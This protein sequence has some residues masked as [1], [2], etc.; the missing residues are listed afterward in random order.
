[1]VSFTS[2]PPDLIL[3][4]A[5]F[6]D[7]TS[8]QQLRLLNHDLNAIVSPL[9]LRNICFALAD[10]EEKIQKLLECCSQPLPALWEY[11]RHLTIRTMGRY[12]AAQY[13]DKERISGLYNTIEQFKH[14][15]SFEIRW[16]QGYDSE[17]T[18]KFVYDIQESVTKAVL[19][20]TGG[21]VGRLNIKP[22]I[23]WAVPLPSGLT[24]FVGLE[25]LA[26]VVKQWECSMLN[27]VFSDGGVW[28]DERKR[29][30]CIQPGYKDAL[31]S[32]IRNNPTLKTMELRQGCV[33]DFYD[34]WALFVG[35]PN[36]T[37]QPLLQDLRTLIINGVT[38]P[39]VISSQMSPFLHL[40]HLEVQSTYRVTPLDNLWLSLQA[41]GT[42]LKTLKTHQVSLSLVSYLALYSGL[43]HLVI[44]DIQGLP[45][46]HSPEVTSKFFQEVLPRHSSSLIQLSI[47]F[48]TGITYLEGWSF[49]PGLWMP[50]LR[51][52]NQLK[53]LRL[54]PGNEERFR[55][56][57]P[58][59]PATGVGGEDRKQELDD[60]YAALTR[61]Y[62]EVL[63]C[64]GSLQHLESLEIVLPG[65][66]WGWC[67]TGRLRW[68]LHSRKI[69]GEVVKRLRSERD[70]PRELILFSGRYDAKKDEDSQGGGW[71][72]VLRPNE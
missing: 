32:L 28:S 67:G 38:F 53:S 44:Q 41:A 2:T 50:A 54:Y 63:D 57:E 8:L 39:H 49:T 18:N 35:S 66:R 52:L 13:V 6:L 68:A 21:K 45:A 56:L 4:I 42:L 48:E 26:F 46:C 12:V 55:E 14:L 20:A 23:S 1:M 30:T 25:H 61:N 47:S 40:E 22:W 71:Q 65:R 69:L 60:K 17:E 31:Q 7:I 34:A 5:E 24:G 27:D 58:R 70:V 16:E 29:H 19:K 15:N 11:G 36:S 62:Q 43:Q 3:T 10:S 64:V 59:S 72:Y 37:A 33:T 51:S 9:A